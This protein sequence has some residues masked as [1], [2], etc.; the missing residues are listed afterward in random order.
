MR[1][2]S[3]LCATLYIC[4][5]LLAEETLRSISLWS[6]YSFK[7]FLSDLFLSERL[8]LVWYQ[9]IRPVS[10]RFKV[11]ERRSSCLVEN[12]IVW[13]LGAVEDDPPTAN[14]GTPTA[15]VPHF[16]TPPVVISLIFRPWFVP[17]CCLLQECKRGIFTGPEAF[18]PNSGWTLGARCGSLR[19]WIKVLISIYWN[20][21]VEKVNFNRCFSNIDMNLAKVWQPWDGVVQWAKGQ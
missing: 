12:L 9:T 2:D 16:K 6:S 15:R 3:T 11:T 8:L 18:L 21:W 5:N 7:F 10:W 17:F 13:L 1:A 14:V 20:I 4:K 19:T